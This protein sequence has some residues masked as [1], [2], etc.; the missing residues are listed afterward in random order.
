M[1]N[2]NNMA[3]QVN[4]YQRTKPSGGLSTNELNE[5]RLRVNTLN[6]IT[7]RLSW[8][9]SLGKQYGGDRDIYRTLGYKDESELSY[10]VYKARYKRQD[11]AKAVIDRPVKYTWRGGVTV[12]ESDDK[13][14]TEFERQ[15]SEMYDAMKLRSVFIRADKITGLGEYSVLLFGFN[16]TGAENWQKPVK[17]GESLRLLYLRPISQPNAKVSKY[18]TDKKSPR[19]GLPILYELKITTAQDARTK[20]VLVHYTRV[21]HILDD[22]LESDIYGTPRLEVLFNRLHD[23][24]KLVGGS[25]EMF[26]RGARPG[27]QNIIDSDFEM[28]PAQKKALKEEIDE[29]E[30]NLRRILN[31]RGGKLEGL[32]VQVSDPKGH[33]DV[34]VQFISSVTGI[35]KRILTGSERGELS[36]AQDAGEMRAFVNDRREEFAEIKIVR[37]FVDRLIELEVLPKPK[38]SYTVQWQDLFAPSDKEK[39]DIGKTRAEALKAYAAE[40]M[41]QAVIPIEVFLDKFLGFDTDTVEWVKEMI[42][43][44]E[45]TALA[46]EEAL[47]RETQNINQ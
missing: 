40:P 42:D 13:D 21:L 4:T 39:A 16:D 18:E 29:Y 17:K 5:M 1:V 10:P 24:E 28:N 47:S 12:F 2:K 7:D 11:I 37:P 34:Q 9:F 33:V 32:A 41:A 26:W 36:S 23:I 38:E 30:H 45:K 31:I 19:Y 15:F 14:E 35:P 3:Q 25:A 27:Y 6:T 8:A 43:G 46:E 20:T 44:A 22:E